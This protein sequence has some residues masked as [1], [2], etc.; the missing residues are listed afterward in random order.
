MRLSFSR[1]STAP[2]PAG[3]ARWPIVAL[4]VGSIVAAVLALTPS[5]ADALPSSE[6]CGPTG[7]IICQKI[8]IGISP[9]GQWEL[10]AFWPGWVFP[11]I[12]F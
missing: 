3:M 2:R 8:E 5:R 10:R 6:G 9:T 1:S 7:F 12:G 11:P 4:L